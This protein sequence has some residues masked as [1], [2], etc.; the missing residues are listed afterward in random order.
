MRLTVII[1]KNLEE[2][3]CARALRQHRDYRQQA[4]FLLWRA[5]EL[6]LVGEDLTLSTWLKQEVAH[7]QKD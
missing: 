7:V 6:D 5:I 2:G 3:F 4:E 1:P